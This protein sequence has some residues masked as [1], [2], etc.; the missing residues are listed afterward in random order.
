MHRVRSSTDIGKI[1]GWTAIVL[2]VLACLVMGV[3]AN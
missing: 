1:I 3:L 2:A